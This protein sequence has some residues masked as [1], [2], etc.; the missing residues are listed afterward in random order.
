MEFKDRIKKLRIEKELTQVD[1]AKILNYGRTAISNYESGR[2][3]PSHD[4]LKRFADY[5]N[6]SI[7]YLL[8]R[9]NVRESIPKNIEKSMELPSELKKL[10]DSA[11]DLGKE[12]I[13]AL[14]NVI[15]VFNKSK[16]KNETKDEISATNEKSDNYRIK[17]IKISIIGKV[18]AGTPI[19]V[20]ENKI[21]EVDYTDDMPRGI[22]FGLVIKGNSMEP[23]IPNSS[24]AWVHKQEEL[25]NGEIGIVMHNGEATC[26]K[27]YLHDDRIE[28][29]SINPEYKPIVITN[30]NFKII[31]KVLNY[32][33]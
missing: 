13:D 7:D 9:I 16:D 30:G 2:S 27:F 5:F 33:I 21:G 25:E 32:K 18:A 15:Q 23:D 31:G 28:L 24:V 17:N 3:K 8:G 14:I 20:I 11:K 19:E 26:K 4:D 10:L 1:L 22:D 29:H 12:Q 6:V